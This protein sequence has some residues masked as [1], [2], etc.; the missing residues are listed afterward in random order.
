MNYTWQP[1]ARNSSPDG[2][3]PN[4]LEI[5]KYKIKIKRMSSDVDEEFV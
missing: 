5:S 2:S 1:S 3:M 4:I